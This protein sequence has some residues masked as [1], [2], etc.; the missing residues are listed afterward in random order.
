MF[1]AVKQGADYRRDVMACHVDALLLGRKDKFRRMKPED[2]PE[3][4]EGLR[5]VLDVA[6]VESPDGFRLDDQTAP[7]VRLIALRIETRTA[8]PRRRRLLFRHGRNPASRLVNAVVPAEY[9]PNNEQRGSG[10]LV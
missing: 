7:T 2:V 4:T 6:E 9:P 1:D 10:G 5:S 8:A 3:L